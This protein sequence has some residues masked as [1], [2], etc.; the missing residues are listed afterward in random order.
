MNEKISKVEIELLS[1]AI[2]KIVSQE[3]LENE[4]LGKLPKVENL[5]DSNKI[6]RGKV[7]VLF[8]DMRE[9]TKLPEQFNAENLV[10]IYTLTILIMFN[11]LL[12]YKVF[13]LYQV[14]FYLVLFYY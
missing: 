11:D 9:S 1:A 7:S 5:N 3:V 13:E 4:I 14:T 2:E 10:K 8:V 12:I 6:Y